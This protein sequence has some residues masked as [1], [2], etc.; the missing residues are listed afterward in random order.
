MPSDT[1]T[2]S[3]ARPDIIRLARF[4]VLA[5]LSLAVLLIVADFLGRGWSDAGLR[6]LSER[7]VIAFVYGI[8]AQIVAAIAA[9]VVL[10]LRK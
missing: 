8:A 5:T 10:E 6:F 3:P 2:S 1:F 4:A 9:V 7:V